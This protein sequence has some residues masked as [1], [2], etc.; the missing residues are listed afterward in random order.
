M[1][2]DILKEIFVKNSRKVLS[3]CILIFI[4]IIVFSTL[5]CEE[6][7]PDYGSATVTLAQGDTP[8]KVVLILSEGEWNENPQFPYWSSM[9]SISE[10]SSTVNLPNMWEHG[11]LNMFSSSIHPSRLDNT[12]ELELTFHT[13]LTNPTAGTY[14][15]EL[16]WRSNPRFDY[17]FD[18]LTNLHWLADGT[19]VGGPVT[20]TV[21]GSN[22]RP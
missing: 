12:N 8:N 13:N 2:R 22:I 18:F 5:S 1:R 6:V 19:G 4:S 21:N 11:I 16:S 14:V 7:K 17:L 9:F 20:I 3:H 15:A 10:I